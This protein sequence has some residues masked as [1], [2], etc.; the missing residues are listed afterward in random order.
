MYIYGYLFSK[1][2][3]ACWKMKNGSKKKK[4]KSLN[5]LAMKKA[6]TTKR[7]NKKGGEGATCP[8]GLRAGF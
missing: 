1:S 8:F 7:T 4:Y 3:F 2:Y 6:T 5:E